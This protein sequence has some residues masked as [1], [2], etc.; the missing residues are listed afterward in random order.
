[1]PTQIANLEAVNSEVLS[2]ARAL[3]ENHPIPPQTFLANSNA[4]KD[5][6]VAA[7]KALYAR[8]SM[9]DEAHDPIIRAVE[10]VL[11]SQSTEV[12]ARLWAVIYRG[13][14]NPNAAGEVVMAFLRQ[15]LPQAEQ[16]FATTADTRACVACVGCLGCASC[17]ACLACII[18]GVISAASTASIA[19][20]ASTA[21]VSH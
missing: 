5:R 2:W 18:T 8:H 9:T 16:Y 10:D 13:D 4:L 19:S 7:Y 17:S 14:F 15:N 3:G 12:Q 20:T 1:M 6:A 21:A 11:Q